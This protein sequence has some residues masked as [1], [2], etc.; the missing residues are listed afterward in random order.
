MTG[1][2]RTGVRKVY[3][4]NFLCKLCLIPMGIIKITVIKNRT[5]SYR[6]WERRI[7]VRNN[8][9]PCSMLFFSKNSD[10]AQ[11]VIRINRRFTASNPPEVNQN[12]TSGNDAVI[13]ME[14]KA[15]Y[16]GNHFIVNKYIKKNM[17]M[18]ARK[19]TIKAFAGR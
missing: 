16:F 10:K 14:R 8:N 13:G 9:S 15:R 18:V 12:M 11:K 6:H 4:L 3:T 1:I 17:K 2:K 7:R 19:F 5:D